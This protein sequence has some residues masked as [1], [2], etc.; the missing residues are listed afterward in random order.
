MK[1][2]LAFLA[3]VSI[4]SPVLAADRGK[5]DAGLDNFQKLAHLK[6]TPKEVSNC[7][8]GK[9]GYTDPILDCMIAAKTQKEIS[10]CLK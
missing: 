8:A 7:V 10:A 2:T 5:C 9:G 6:K 3:L 1:A 4:S